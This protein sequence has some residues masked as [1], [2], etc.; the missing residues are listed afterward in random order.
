MSDSFWPSHQVAER[1][2]HGLLVPAV[3]THCRGRLVCLL[4]WQPELGPILSL[5]HPKKKKIHRYI[6]REAITVYLTNSGIWCINQISVDLS[7]WGNEIL[8]KRPHNHYNQK[9]FIG[10]KCSSHFL[11]GLQHPQMH[12]LANRYRPNMHRT[13]ELFYIIEFK[14]YFIKT[15]LDQIFKPLNPVMKSYF[16]FPYSLSGKWYFTPNLKQM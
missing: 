15:K 12:W 3:L 7:F 16:F 2:L 14:T 13:P 6:S 11:I 5:C 1:R 8:R 4:P 9:T 10:V